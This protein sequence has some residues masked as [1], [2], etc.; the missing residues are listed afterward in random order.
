MILS[1]ILIRQEGLCVK[2]VKPV[3]QGQEGHRHANFS[4]MTSSLLKSYF[5]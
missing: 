2:I 1:L 4:G 5:R 3:N